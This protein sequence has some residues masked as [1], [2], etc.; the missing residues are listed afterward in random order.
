M[1]TSRKLL[2]MAFVAAITFILTACGTSE[3]ERSPI[4]SSGTMEEDYQGKQNPSVTGQILLSEE[5][6]KNGVK[7]IKIKCGVEI[8]APVQ[9]QQ[10]EKEKVQDDTESD[11]GGKS[12]GGPHI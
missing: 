1:Q 4:I 6:K 12:N 2:I 3:E 10:T 11:S 5:E 7:K 9:N 8:E